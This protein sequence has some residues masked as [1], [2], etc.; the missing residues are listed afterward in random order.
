MN[1]EQPL[2][3][4]LLSVDQLAQHARQLAGRHETIDAI[5]T[6][7][8]LPRLDQNEVVLL[9][10]HAVVNDAAEANRRI[11]PAAEW[12]ID[13]FYLIE[14]QVRISRRHLPKGYSRELTKL[15]A[16]S[17]KG[18]PRV[19]DIA[20]EL[21]SHIDGRIDSESLGA[22]IASYQSVAPLKLGEIWAVP[23]M[24]RL[25]LI[26]NLRRVA[27]R[28]AASQEDRD[29]AFEWSESMT[30][31]S[32][33][34]PDGVL[35]ALANMVRERPDLSPAFTAEFARRMQG[36]GSRMS[37]PLRWLEE[38][39]GERGMNIEQLVQTDSREQAAD[40][41]SIGNSIGSLRHLSAI[42]WKEFVEQHSVVERTL[43][44]DP[45]EIHAVQDFTT[46]DRYRHVVEKVAR[47]S[48]KDEQDVADLAISLA[49]SEPATSRKTHVGYQLVDDGL[50]RLEARTGVRLGTWAAIKR[51]AKVNAFT[52]FLG[53]IVAI[54]IA[55]TAAVL[56]WTNATG[57]SIALVVV[58]ALPLLIAASQLG[59]ATVNWLAAR[60][61][62]PNR[63]PRLDFSEGI[64]TEARTIVAVP[65]MLT[66][67]AG[68]RELLDNLEVR[69]LANRD[70]NLFFALL[71][72]FGDC[73]S[74]TRD[75][76]ADLLRQAVDGVRQ[77]NQT[78][79]DDG[80]HFFLL[81]RPRL[82]NP[83]QQCW[84]GQ[85]RKRGKLEDF[86]ALLR[87]ENGNAD[88]AFSEIV[89]DRSVLPTIKYV[90]ALDADTMLP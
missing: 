65:C 35:L 48:R 33:E 30:S 74:E 78:H 46:R 55:V 52:L 75:L 89:G 32:A 22:F 11:T 69:H 39:L 27:A 61:V 86:N 67:A 84:M 41:V 34:K 71:S 21:I 59:V 15:A 38:R 31:I 25:A 54:A 42:D 3:R 85:E 29:R 8:L 80:E 16:G 72:D 70:A 43:Q 76:D 88:E 37:L 10:A 50:H 51:I 62:G 82:W 23:I 53:G 68:V 36:A 18:F 40:Q 58:V 9:R 87:D 47:R 4:D 1:D 17:S 79:G 44:R 83:K 26:E 66:S 2:R 13:N 24:L 90:I 45:A 14:E 73:D 77:L 56:G 6:D 49:K 60:M 19:Y 12:L 64:P 81:H 20:L 57:G 63:L 28:I 7:H 5:G